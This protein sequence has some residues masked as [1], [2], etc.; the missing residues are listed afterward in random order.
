MVYATYTVADGSH[1]QSKCYF[2][3]RTAQTTC[4]DSTKTVEYFRNICTLT[5]CDVERSFSSC[6]NVLTDTKLPFSEVELGAVVQLYSV[7][8]HSLLI[9][10]FEKRFVRARGR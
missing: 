10:G 3:R 6:K 7:T 1:A 2:G 9:I 5:S 8:M 4:C